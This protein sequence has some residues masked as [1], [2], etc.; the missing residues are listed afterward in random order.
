[1]NGTLER[2]LPSTE[3]N[4]TYTFDDADE[5]EVTLTVTDE[6]GLTKHGYTQYS[7]SSQ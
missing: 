1:M 4:P 2:E 3:A 6:L 7:G 5:Y